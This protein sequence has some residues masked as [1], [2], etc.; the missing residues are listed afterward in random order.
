MGSQWRHIMKKDIKHISFRTT[1]EMLKKFNYV[2]AYDDRSMNWLMMKLV[3]NYIAKFEAKH[4]K[5]E[6]DEENA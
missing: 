2:A 6:F 4:G 1:S 3:A 5:I